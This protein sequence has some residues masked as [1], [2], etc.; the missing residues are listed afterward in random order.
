MATLTT[1]SAHMPERL[2][3]ALLLSPPGLFDALLAVCRPLRDARTAAQVHI[4]R[5]AGA[6]AALR[7]HLAEVLAPHGVVGEPMLDWLS[8]TLEREPVPGNLPPL[9][10]LGEAARRL[11]LDH[12]AA[13]AAAAGEEG[14]AGA[15]AGREKFK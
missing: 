14:K 10:R 15:E 9:E 13:A 2:E 1:F 11:R 8:D 3:A 7:A 5:P 4:L 6:G 12:A